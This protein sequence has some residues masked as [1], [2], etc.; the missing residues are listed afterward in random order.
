MRN[1]AVF[2]VF[3]IA[4]VAYNAFTTAER[5]SNGAIVSDGSIDAFKV[6]IGDCFNDTGPLATGEDGEIHSLPGVPC[7]EPHD[8]EVYAVFDVSFESYPGGDT[9]SSQAFAACRDRFEAFVG[10]D[11]ES[12]SLDISTLYPTRDSWKYQNDREVVCAVFDVDAR[13][14]TGSVAGKAI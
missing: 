3:A 8:N 6:R 2:A 13:K 7:S 10:M 9:M 1:L 14:L 5:D 4:A 11:Y 12:S